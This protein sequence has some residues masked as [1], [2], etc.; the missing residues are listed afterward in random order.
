MCHAMDTSDKWGMIFNELHY[1]P[2]FQTLRYSHTICT[3]ANQFGCQTLI[4]QTPKN[5]EKI[6]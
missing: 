5:V 4:K 1:Q 3:K 6:H 2:Y